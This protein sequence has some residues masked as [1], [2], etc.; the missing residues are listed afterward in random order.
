MGRAADPDFARRFER[1]TESLRDHSSRRSRE[2]F[3]RFLQ[4]ARQLGRRQANA[5]AT[6]ASWL[7]SLQA[8]ERRV[9]SAAGPAKRPNSTNR[10]RSDRAYLVE[11]NDRAELVAEGWRRHRSELAFARSL[12]GT[13]GVKTTDGRR[14]CSAGRQ[15]MGQLQRL[16]GRLDATFGEG[17]GPHQLFA[18]GPVR[19]S[20]DNRQVD[21]IGKL[22]GDHDAV[23]HHLL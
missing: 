16:E 2:S 8:L 13:S 5:Q 7:A 15:L 10:D 20:R 9:G 4:V 14:S 18:A 23:D 6:P 11:R 22:H 3:P 1:L 17:L 21:R 19:P 12:P